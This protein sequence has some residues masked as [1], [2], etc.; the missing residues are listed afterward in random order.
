MLRPFPSLPEEPPHQC[1]RYEHTRQPGRREAQ[2]SNRL[3]GRF[4]HPLTNS[5]GYLPFGEPVT[6]RTESVPRTGI[7]A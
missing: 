5:P 6:I 3:P 7:P 4:L 2:V 1:R